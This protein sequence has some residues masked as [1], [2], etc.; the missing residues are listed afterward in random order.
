MR[1]WGNTD[2]GK[3]FCPGTKYYGATKR[4]SYVDSSIVGQKVRPRGTKLWQAA[5]RG[6][7][8]I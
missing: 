8:C 5:K 1:V 2:S 4:G 7:T 3:L 6:G